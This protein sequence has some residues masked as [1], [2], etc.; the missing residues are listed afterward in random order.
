MQLCLIPPLSCAGTTSYF[1][2][3][4]THAM[5]ERD[6]GPAAAYQPPSAAFDGSTTYN[7]RECV[8]AFADGLRLI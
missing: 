5:P 1:N 6:H 4:V 3:Y 8:C 7:V 2:D